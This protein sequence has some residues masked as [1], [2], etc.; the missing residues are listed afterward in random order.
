MRLFAAL[1]LSLFCLAF[2]C[3][4]RTLTNTRWKVLE[5]RLANSSNTLYPTKTYIVE[6]RDS[7]SIGI[8]LD[9]NTCGGGYK[10]SK[11]NTIEISPLACTKACCDSELAQNI[12]MTLSEMTVVKGSSKK[13]VLENPTKRSTIKLELVEK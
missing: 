9:I 2:S 8:K 11:D 4:R 1:L 12:A 7:T 13:L 10:L 5:L 6:F 3:Q